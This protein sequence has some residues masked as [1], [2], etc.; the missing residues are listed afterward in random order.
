MSVPEPG[1]AYTP[2]EA[3]EFLRTTATALRAQVSRKQIPHTRVGKYVRFSADDIA[4]ILAAGQRPPADKPAASAPRRA[5]RK[6][7]APPPPPAGIT[8]LRARPDAARP[9]RKATGT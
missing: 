7:A 5:T 1:H 3:A 4:Q 2:E 9:K 8:P 6:T